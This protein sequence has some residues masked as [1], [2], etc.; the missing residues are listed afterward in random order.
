MKFKLFQSAF[1]TS[2]CLCYNMHC[3]IYNCVS[4]GFLI[5]SAREAFKLAIKLPFRDLIIF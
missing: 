5:I 4:C 3:V 1:F 2:V